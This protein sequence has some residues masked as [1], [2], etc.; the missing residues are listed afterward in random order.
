MKQH[1]GYF[2]TDLIILNRRQMMRTIPEL[3]P[4]LQTSAPHQRCFGL[5]T[6]DLPRTGP[7]YTAF[8]RWIRASSLEPSGPEAE[9]LPLGHSASR[10]L[11]DNNFA[12]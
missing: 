4:P 3:A 1:Q 5:A 2:G 11:S 8:L 10:K 9:A 7:A 12:L 6:M